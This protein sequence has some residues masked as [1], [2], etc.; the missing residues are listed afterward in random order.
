MILKNQ[1]NN[2]D[3]QS[4]SKNKTQLY[5]VWASQVALVV[6]DPPVNVGDS[7][8]IPGLGRSPWREELQPTP[9]FLPGELHGLY[10]PWGREES[11][12]IEQL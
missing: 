8:S 1:L 6:K 4:G 11:D 5:V 3:C 9:A 2:R 10:S 12:T 7:G